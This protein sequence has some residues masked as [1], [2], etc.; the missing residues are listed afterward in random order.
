MCLLRLRNKKHNESHAKYSVS[1]THF[2]KC[3]GQ[4]SEDICIHLRHP[5]DGKQTQLW[6]SFHIYPESWNHLV[7]E[8]Q[9]QEICGRAG[10]GRAGACLQPPT[11][12]SA[13]QLQ[14]ALF[15]NIKTF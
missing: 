12:E 10:D 3:L 9:I 2:A 4:G 15:I 1:R 14:W 11:L 8:T 5:G 7:T 6:L 13:P